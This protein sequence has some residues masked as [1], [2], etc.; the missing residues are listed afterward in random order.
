MIKYYFKILSMLIR[1]F[2]FIKKIQVFVTAYAG[3][4][5]LLPKFFSRKHSIIF[6]LRPILLG[7]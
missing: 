1:I 7:E 2:K 5:Y 3:F 6:F 4:T